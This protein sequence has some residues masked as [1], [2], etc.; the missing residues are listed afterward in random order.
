MVQNGVLISKLAII[1][2]YLKKLQGYF[3]VSLEQFSS[4]WGL[5]KIV[6]RSLQVMIEVMIDIAERIV[7]QKG[8]LPQK[9]A[10]DTLKKLRELS[11]IQ[12]DEAY[13]KMVRFRNLV[14]HQ[15]DSIDMGI[16]YSIVQNNLEDFR[17][18]ID[19]IKKYEGI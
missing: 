8:I 18:F 7:A 15:Y 19:E 1:E 13:I 16:L 3:P 5:Q 9:T 12:N 11:I 14:V 6:E 10:A 17:M 2:E 4:D